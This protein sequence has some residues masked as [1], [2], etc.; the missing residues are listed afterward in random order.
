MPDARLSVYSLVGEVQEWDESILNGRF[1]GTP[2][3]MHPGSFTIAQGV[4]K[5]RFRVRTE[6]LGVFLRD[7]PV[8]EVTLMV[9]RHTGEARTC[10]LVH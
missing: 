3:E 1:P 8:A 9:V 4:L 5:G 10:G 6:A 7:Q 2:N